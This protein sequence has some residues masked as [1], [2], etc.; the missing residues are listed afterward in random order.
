M[1]TTKSFAKDEPYSPTGF[2]EKQRI[3]ARAEYR[4]VVLALAQDQ[5]PGQVDLSAILFSVCKSFDDMDADITL[6]RQ[7]YD[8]FQQRMAAREQAEGAKQ[9]RDRLATVEAEANEL[10]RQFKQKIEPLLEQQQSLKREAEL[11]ESHSKG[12]LETSQR[13]LERT[14]DPAIDLTIQSVQKRHSDTLERINLLRSDSGS[15]RWSKK[16]EEE[17]KAFEERVE[18]LQA[19]KRLE[20]DDYDKLIRWK[21]RQAAQQELPLL[22]EREKELQQ[23]IYDAYALKLGWD[24]VA[25][26]PVGTDC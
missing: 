6:V 14:A 8:L 3:L 7:R 25:L 19:K 22:E 12:V 24:R 20:Q 9:V 2:I 21:K 1:A 17:L 13:L 23:E 15:K 4:R 10:S 18:A 5:E 16:E 26:F 11:L